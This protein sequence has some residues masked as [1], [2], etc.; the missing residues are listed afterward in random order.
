MNEDILSELLSGEEPE[1]K[2]ETG[3]KDFR[4]QFNV[5]EEF[6]LWIREEFPDLENYTNGRRVYHEL[7]ERKEEVYQAALGA[8]N[9]GME[10]TG[11][12]AKAKLYQGWSAFETGFGRGGTSRKRPRGL[13]KFVE[14][15]EALSI[16][17]KGDPHYTHAGTFLDGR[18][19][20]MRNRK[21]YIYRVG[22]EF[23]KKTTYLVFD[24]EQEF[25]EEGP[26]LIGELTGLTKW[27]CEQLEKITASFRGTENKFRERV[28]LIVPEGGVYTQTPRTSP[29]S[30]VSRARPSYLGPGQGYYG[31][32]GTPYGY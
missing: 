5:R 16:S 1:D 12:C 9:H 28:D 25:R 30:R 23:S 14:A 15:L 7:E 6:V 18:A 10:S 26:V 22:K 11:A 27:D 32:G 21:A 17:L 24:E 13:G 20:S 19:F 31:Y 3:R 2:T 4:P 8:V 29:T